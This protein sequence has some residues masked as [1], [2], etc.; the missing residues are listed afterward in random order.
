MNNAVAR[1]VIQDFSDRGM[2][3]ALPNSVV[4]PGYSNDK[5]PQTPETIGFIV[6]A[7]LV[8]GILTWQIY[9]IGGSRLIR[10]I[11]VIETSHDF[12]WEFD[13]IERASDW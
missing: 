9:Q 13:E 8:C 10:S 1:R 4:E 11:P 6:S 7:V 2:P 5:S 3:S 12:D